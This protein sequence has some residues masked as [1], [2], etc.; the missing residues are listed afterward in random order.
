MTLELYRDVAPQHADSFAARTKE[1]FYT[2]LIFHRI[3][4]NFMI[5]SGDPTGTGGGKALYHLNSEFSKLLHQE[6]TLSMARFG[7][8]PNS[9]STQFFICLAR[10]SATA[11]LDGEYS[12]FGQLIKG[13]DVLHSIGKVELGF[14][15][16]GNKTKPVS[17]VYIREAFVSDSEGNKI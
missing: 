9:A 7:N 8:N 11:S 3:V 16:R 15:S 10:N 4:P 1:G 14:N 17:D 5:Q 12:I 13:Y 2:G 6:G